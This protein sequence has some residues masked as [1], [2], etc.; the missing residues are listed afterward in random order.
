MQKLLTVFLLIAFSFA[1]GYP[2]EGNLISFKFKS[3]TIQ[4]YFSKQFISG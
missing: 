4:I 1:N 2:F 3:L